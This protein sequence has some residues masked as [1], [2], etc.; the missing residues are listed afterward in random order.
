VLEVAKQYSSEYISTY[1]ELVKVSAVED[2]VSFAA[3]LLIHELHIDL[4]REPRQLESVIAAI[5]G[6]TSITLTLSVSSLD[7]TSGRTISPPL[8]VFL[9]KLSTLWDRIASSSPP[10]LLFSTHPSH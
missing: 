8:S 9:R 6:T 10:P 5:K 7:E 3:R 4:D 1:A 2:N